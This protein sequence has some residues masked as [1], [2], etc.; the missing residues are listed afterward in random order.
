MDADKNLEEWL[1][2]KILDGGKCICDYCG[3]KGKLAATALDQNTGEILVMCIS[4]DIRRMAKQYG[5]TIAEARKKRRKRFDCLYLFQEIKYQ[6]YLSR[7][8]KT[9]FDSLEEFKRIAEIVQGA[10]N[11]LTTEE[12]RGFE[13]KSKIVLRKIHKTIKVEFPL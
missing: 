5:I 1:K 8:G 3:S 7:V 10:W 6:D 11:A 4:C 2:G 9:D 12:R 13:D